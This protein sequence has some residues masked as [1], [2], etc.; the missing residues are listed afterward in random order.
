YYRLA[1]MFERLKRPHAEV[2]FAYLKASWQVE[3]DKKRSRQYLSSCLEAYEKFLKTKPKQSER[4]QTA[5]FLKGELLRQ[6]GKFD[7]A[8]KHFQEIQKLAEFKK[9]PFPKLIELELK[10]IGKKDD[11]PRVIPA[12]KKDE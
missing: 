2:A 7:D 3:D 4:T 1:R 12:G 10:L 11:K 9:A 6:L 5:Q 8:S